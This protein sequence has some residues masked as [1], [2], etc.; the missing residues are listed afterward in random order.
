MQIS[1]RNILNA[2]CADNN[3]DTKYQC[4]VFIKVSHKEV[5]FLRKILRS[6]SDD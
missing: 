6:K 1:F 4:D 2:F 3:L 5:F